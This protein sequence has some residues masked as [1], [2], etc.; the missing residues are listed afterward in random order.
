LNLAYNQRAVALHELRQNELALADLDESLKFA[1]NVKNLAWR[2]TRAEVLA[3]LGQHQPAMTE[4]EALLKQPPSIVT[5][6]H[7]QIACVCSLCSSAVRGDTAVSKTEQSRLS[8]QYATRAMELLKKTKAAGLTAAQ[9]EE[10]WQDK[11]LE[12][13]RKRPDFQKLFPKPLPK[14]QSKKGP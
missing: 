5:A 11:D 10:M 4:V 1:E 14:E 7:Y 6:L 8:E 3:A 13:L 2:M 12:P 9:I